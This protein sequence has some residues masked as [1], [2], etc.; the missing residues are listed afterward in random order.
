MR[1]HASTLA[2]MGLAVREK[3]ARYRA[4]RERVGPGS[5]VDV[6]DNSVPFSSVEWLA[7]RLG[8]ET[9]ELL[10][11]IGIAGRTAIRRKAHGYLRAD[12]ADRL[13]RV[14]RVLEE[15]SRVFGTA[16]KAATLFFELTL[17]SVHS[18][19]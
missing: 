10:N 14:A 12:E 18:W 8:V 6:H 2:A 19:I 9:G 13:L 5:L 15:A 11:V 4:G 3:R 1:A 16:E 7:N 17:N